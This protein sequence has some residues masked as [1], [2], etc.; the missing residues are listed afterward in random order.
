M[1]KISDNQNNCPACPRC[2]GSSI[3]LHWNSGLPGDGIGAQHTARNLS[4]GHPIAGVLGLLFIGAKMTCSSIY[5]CRACDHQWRG[6][7]KS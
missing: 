7:L 4:G 2:S 3:R 6:W 1:S 5:K